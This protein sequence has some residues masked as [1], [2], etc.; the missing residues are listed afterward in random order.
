MN[1]TFITAPEKLLCVAEESDSSL[2]AWSR[3][4]AHHAQLMVVKRKGALIGAMSAKAFRA[5][6]H[7]AVAASVGQLPVKSV[8]VLPHLARLSEIL[9][10]FAIEAVEAVILVDGERM[11]S[12][13]MRPD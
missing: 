5:V 1:L 11:V 2:S 3:F 7:G 13:V 10:Q 6:M 4:Q 9:R 12:V 8:A